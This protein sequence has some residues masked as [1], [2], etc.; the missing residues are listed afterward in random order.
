MGPLHEA[1][2]ASSQHGTQ[3]SR[4]TLPI[5]GKWELPVSSDLDSETGTMWLPLYSIDK[6]VTEATTVQEEGT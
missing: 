5:D 2:W 6:V 3:V 4:A 1:A